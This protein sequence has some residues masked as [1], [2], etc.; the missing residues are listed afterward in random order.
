MKF[1]FLGFI[2]SCVFLALGACVSQDS[3]QEMDINE[4]QAIEISADEAINRA[5]SYLD[6]RRIDHRQS[7]VVAQWHSDAWQIHFYAEP[8]KPGGDFTVMVSHDGR[9]IELIPGM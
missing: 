1:R 3:A 7:R 4:A 5:V 2:S 8:P 9:I 6:S